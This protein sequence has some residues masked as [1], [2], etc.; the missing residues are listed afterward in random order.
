MTNSISLTIPLNDYNALTRAADMLHGLV[1][2]MKRQG[3][4]PVGGMDEWEQKTDEQVVADLDALQKQV[5]ASS[6]ACDDQFAPD[7]AAVVVTPVETTAAEAFPNVDQ[8][9]TVSATP[10]VVTATQ[11]PA[12]AGV[13][14][15]KDSTGANVPWDERIHSKGDKRTKAD[16]S[17]KLARGIDKT[18][19]QT[20][21]AELR[22]AMAVPAPNEPVAVVVSPTA[23][24]AIVPT[25]E[26]VPNVQSPVVT[27]TVAAG[28]TANPSSAPVVAAQPVDTAITTLP[29]L[30]AAATGAGKTQADM[31]EAAVA[32]GIASVALLGARPDLI[33]AV[34]K[35]LGLGG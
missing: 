21:E 11:S 6:T 31:Q 14:L 10:T 33:P 2:D 20:V 35:S 23:T 5:G 7:P 9:T 15:A 3:N 25:V 29:A 22:A 4:E 13:E 32:A 18:L 16:G 34:A 27:A 30:M 8:S 26:A 28:S 1:I 17:W 24:P 12:S 19:V